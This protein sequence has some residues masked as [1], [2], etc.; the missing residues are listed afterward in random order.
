MKTLLFVIVF[1]LQ[2]PRIIYR[3]LLVL[4]GEYHELQKNGEKSDSGKSL[5]APMIM[6]TL[7]TYSLTTHLE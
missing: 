6:N 7:V 3:F 4:L 2:V 5:H 1:A